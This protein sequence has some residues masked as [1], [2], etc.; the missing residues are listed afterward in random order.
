[1]EKEKFDQALQDAVLKHDEKHVPSFNR[2]RVWNKSKAGSGNRT[3][4]Y[5]ALS[6]AV[7][8]LM[9]FALSFYDNEK[10]PFQQANDK[11]QNPKRDQAVRQSDRT[12]A[13][14][15]E[16]LIEGQRIDRT[17]TTIAE[18]LESVDLTASAI[19]KPGSVTINTAISGIM[20]AKTEHTASV[21][22]QRSESVTGVQAQHPNGTA[23]IKAHEEVVRKEVAISEATYAALSTVTFK[24]GKPQE[25]EAVLPVKVSLFKG[26]SPVF[27]YNKALPGDSLYY[28]EAKP[29]KFKIKF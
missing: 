19:I 21:K 28:V 22:E 20:P 18:K 5:S 9:A 6:A 29:F 2:N 23:S 1:M 15:K 14:V 10:H 13:T 3:K 27:N 16:K 26:K 4:L 11:F 24:R 17:K 25:A 7:I 12:E 8:L